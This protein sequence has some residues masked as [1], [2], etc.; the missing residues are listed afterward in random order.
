MIQWVKFGLMIM[1]NI[2]NITNGL[3]LILQASK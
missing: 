3:D 2:V 1:F